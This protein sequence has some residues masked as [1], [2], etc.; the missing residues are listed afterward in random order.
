MTKNVSGTQICLM[1]SA[2]T[3]SFSRSTCRS[4]ASLKKSNK[5]CKLAY[6]SPLAHVLPGIRPELPEV[7]VEGEVHELL[8]EVADAEDVEGDPDSD[9]LASIVGADSTVITNLG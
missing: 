2:P 8:A 7:H 3:T 4:K 6:H 9:G 5:V 1:Y